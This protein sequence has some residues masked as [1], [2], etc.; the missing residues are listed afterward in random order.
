VPPLQRMHAPGPTKQDTDSAIFLHISPA[1]GLDLACD[2]C[3]K[4]H[5]RHGEGRNPVSN[6]LAR[7]TQ[8]GKM[9]KSP[10]AGLSLASAALPAYGD[11]LS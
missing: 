4:W 9:A 1:S 2:T 11:K 10:H 5:P 7:I 3:L 6:L 8:G